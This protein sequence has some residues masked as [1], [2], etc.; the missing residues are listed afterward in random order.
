[1]NR[2]GLA[3]SWLEATI[4]VTTDCPVGTS[5]PRAA[6][7]HLLSV[8]TTSWSCCSKEQSQHL[9][10]HTAGAAH[11]SRAGGRAGPS[12]NTRAPRPKNTLGGRCPATNWTSFLLHRALLP[13]QPVTL[14]HR[15]FPIK[16]KMTLHRRQHRPHLKLPLWSQFIKIFTRPDAGKP[17]RCAC[18]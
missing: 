13:N 6:A 1:M 17:K 4:R 8:G 5:K 18:S 16:L 15:R 14:S 9:Q 12:V 10:H 7:G 11:G 2:K 3:E